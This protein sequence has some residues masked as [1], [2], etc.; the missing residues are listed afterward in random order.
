MNVP[1]CSTASLYDLHWKAD[2]PLI[3]PA[4]KFL[5]FKEAKWPLPCSQNPWASPAQQ[6]Q[7]SQATQFFRDPFNKDRSKKKVEQQ[8]K[9]MEQ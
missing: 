8:Q 9:C 6:S 2:K 7:P 3:Q 1:N 5:A 4:N